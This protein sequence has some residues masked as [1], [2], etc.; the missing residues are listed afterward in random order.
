ML[1]HQKQML[2]YF[3]YKYSK[4]LGSSTVELHTLV[5]G[6]ISGT[7]E[8]KTPFPSEDQFQF[9]AH[10]SRDL[11]S[12][13][14]RVFV[15]SKLLGVELIALNVVDWLNLSFSEWL[16]VLH[17]C[18]S[19]VII[20]NI[21]FAW[22]ATAVAWFAPQ[23]LFYIMIMVSVVWSQSSHSRKFQ[24]YLVPQSLKLYWK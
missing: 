15:L 18:C 22:N 20:G 2:R 13:C 9:L 1:L 6:T 14:F 23:L 17:S 11:L 12:L 19:A 21:I 8:Q 3:V 10:S 16:S 4:R 5:S 24:K 7:Q